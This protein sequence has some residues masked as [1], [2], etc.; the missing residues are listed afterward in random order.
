MNEVSNSA[1]MSLNQVDYLK[2]LRTLAIVIGGAVVSFALQQLQIIDF[3]QYQ[4]V[5]TV[6][7]VPLLELA[8]RYFTDHTV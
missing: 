8:R 2:T 7:V 4:Q 6:I 1:K 3:G 5:V